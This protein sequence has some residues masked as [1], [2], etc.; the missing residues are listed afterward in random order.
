M[1]ITGDRAGLEARNDA[2]EAPEWNKA[3]APAKASSAVT[4]RMPRPKGS[5]ARG[6]PPLSSSS[7]SRKMALASSTCISC[8]IVT[9]DKGSLQECL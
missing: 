5:A 9:T 7:S 8:V 4:A 3:A 2:V 6:A 1:L